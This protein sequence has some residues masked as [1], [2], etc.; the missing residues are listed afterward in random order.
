MKKL[1]LLP[2][3]FLLIGFNA[4]AQNYNTKVNIWN[5]SPIFTVGDTVFIDIK[6]STIGVIT[7][8][9]S[10]DVYQWSYLPVRTGKK[11]LCYKISILDLELIPKQSNGTRRLKFVCPQPIGTTDQFITKWADGQR[12]YTSVITNYFDEVYLKEYESK[13]YD[14]NG[15]ECVPIEGLYIKETK[16][17]REKIFITK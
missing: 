2:I 6:Y 15:I 1:I 10:L 13:Y 4:N 5:Y 9:D 14:L 8:V 11:F 7:N 3:I 12:I 17:K 16:G